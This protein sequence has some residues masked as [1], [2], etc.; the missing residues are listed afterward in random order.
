MRCRYR[1][2]NLE[3]L[4]QSA[5]IR[6]RLTPRLTAVLLLPTRWVHKFHIRAFAVAHER[7]DDFGDTSL[8]EENAVQ[9]VH[10]WHVDI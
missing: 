4:A 5:R 8:L 2:R 10:Q 9:T 1:A 3:V 6:A 7:A